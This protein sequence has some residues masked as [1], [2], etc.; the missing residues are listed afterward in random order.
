MTDPTLIPVTDPTLIPVTDPTLIPVTD[1]TLS[2]IH[3]CPYAIYSTK[4]L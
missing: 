4:V 2:V 3:L 1:P